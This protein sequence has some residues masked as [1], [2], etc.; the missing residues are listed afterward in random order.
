M[1]GVIFNLIGIYHILGGSCSLHHHVQNDFWGT[2]VTTYY[3]TQR[4]VP[5]DPSLNIHRHDNL[6]YHTIIFLDNGEELN[7]LMCVLYLT[8]RFIVYCGSNVAFNY[9]IPRKWPQDA[10]TCPD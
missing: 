3:T 2:S 7:Y 6:E 9:W 10:D 4:H 8:S 5:T 1:G